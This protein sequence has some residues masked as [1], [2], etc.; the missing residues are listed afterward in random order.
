MKWL[1]RFIENG[2]L[3]TGNPG[4]GLPRP[5]IE[6]QLEKIIKL[7]EEIAESRKVQ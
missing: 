2:K 4:T 1:R 6:D 7:L 3:P 5:R